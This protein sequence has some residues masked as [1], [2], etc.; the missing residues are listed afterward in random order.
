MHKKGGNM[1]ANL[2]RVLILML[3][4]IV[5]TIFSAEETP[6]DQT[7]QGMVFVK[8]GPFLMGNDKIFNEEEPVHD[9]TLNPF[10][11]GKF[12]VT[13]K[14]WQ[15]VMGNNPSLFKNENNPVENVTWYDTVEYCNKRSQ[16]EG[17]TPCYQGSADDI[18]CNFDADGYRLPTEA[19]WE[20]A[21]RGGSKSQNYTFSGSNNPDEVAW[22]EKNSMEPHAVGQKKPNEIGLYDMSGNIWEW[23]WD[24]YDKDYYKNS[25]ST[26][27]RGPAA[28]KNRSY[29]S[30][31]C[32]GQIEWLRCTGRYNIPPSY[33]RYNMGFRVVKN[34]SHP[35]QSPAGTVLI[36]GGTF[37]MG[38]TKV[39]TG[40]KFVH[41][42]TLK[43]FYIG[44]FEVT[45]EEWKTVMGKN[46]SV[47]IGA[48]CPVESI[49][50][51]DAVEY[52]N[53][54]S[55][56]EGLTPCYSGKGDDITC[57]FDAD[58][59]R[60]PT[61]AEWEYACRGGALSQNYTFSGSNNP[62]EVGWYAGN[63]DRIQP[64]GQKKPNELGIYDMSGNV[65]EW[66]WDWYG[67]DYYEN[68]EAENPKGVSSDI[69]RVARGGYAT[70]SEN[71]L[72]C[73]LRFSI[74]P[75]RS[76]SA[77]GLRVVRNAK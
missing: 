65:L 12:E 77:L 38:N 76:L 49:N 73:T 13:Q 68:S 34:A 29:R 24:W 42:V 5:G 59:Y 37:R 17:L 55:R 11:I 53:K 10:Y 35:G 7:P 41:R 61:E 56:M 14:E 57:N 15:A 58:G 71:F 62:Q 52:C 63:T 32:G 40:E 72:T 21:C 27:P 75:N 19:E 31:G 54:R 1:K 46:P 6:R 67:F 33:K 25:P 74:K 26:N 9:V 47:I 8:G 2:F 16:L 39:T 45:Q 50:W 70:G 43:D 23:C 28:G 4:L 60:L 64:I 66:C 48:L 36:E 22:H 3:F 51:Y 20:Y 18:T 69:R 30:G 44:K